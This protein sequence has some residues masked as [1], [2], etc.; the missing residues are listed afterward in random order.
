MK[1]LL[2]LPLLFIGC[3]DDASTTTNNTTDART[4]IINNFSGDQAQL[5][6]EAEF[7]EITIDVTQE[8][9]VLCGDPIEIDS[10]IEVNDPELLAKVLSE[11]E[12][13]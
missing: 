6:D 13:Q 8:G 1:A 12:V 2:L 5:F 10:V 3:G 7:A 4:C 11:G 9:F